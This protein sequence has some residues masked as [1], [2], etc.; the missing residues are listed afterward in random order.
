MN[1]SF[2]R[3][4]RPLMPG[5]LTMAWATAAWA[6]PADT[7]LEPVVVTP[8]R[9]PVPLRE[10]L[11]DVT[12]IERGPILILLRDS[13]AAPMVSK[14]ATD[15]PVKVQSGAKLRGRGTRMAKRPE[16]TS[17]LINTV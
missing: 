4:A 6:A 10:V 3:H 9:T 13:R 7:R 5:L 8:T 2:R 12:V 11:S 14:P 1:F 16:S 17:A 15:E